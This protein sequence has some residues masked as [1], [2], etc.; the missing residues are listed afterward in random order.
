MRPAAIIR[1]PLPYF[2]DASH[3]L[4]QLDGMQHRVWLDSG[5]QAPERGRW[6]ILSAAPVESWPN[7]NA[8]TLDTALS[9]LS[10]NGE[11]LPFTGGLIGHFDYESRHPHFK[12]PRTLEATS[13]WHLYLWAILVDHAEQRALLV[14]QPTLPTHSVEDLKQRLCTTPLNSTGYRSSAFRAEMPK[15]TYEEALERIRQYILEGDCY[16][17]NFAQRFRAHFE[18]DPLQ[19]YCTVRKTLSGAYS[20]YFEQPCGTLLSFSPEQFIGVNGRKAQSRPIKGTSPRGQSPQDDQELAQALLNSEKNRAE[21]LM[22]VD[23]LRNDFNRHCKPFS[24]AVPELFTLES[25]ANVHHLVST[26]TGELPAE[27]ASATLVLDSFPGG[28]ITGAPKRRAMEIIDELEPEPRRIYCGSIGYFSANA[29]CDSN[30]AIR[31]M[32]LEN[33]DLYCWGGGGIVADSDTEDEWR[34]SRAKVDMLMRALEQGG[35]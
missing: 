4:R 24:V 35:E 7:P 16:Q 26:I 15:S 5:Q 25:Y 30:I 34:E 6:D 1:H 33:E 18:G 8:D 11:D 17:V 28:S 29:R 2:R 31:T 21:N 23:L 13:H 19:A 32:L 27:C 20:A 10:T 9:A 12:L 3:Y 14:C 22:I